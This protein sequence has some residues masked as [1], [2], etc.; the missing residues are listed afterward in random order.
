MRGERSPGSIHAS[1][2]AGSAPRAWGTHVPQQPERPGVRISPT[3]VGNASGTTGFPVSWPDQPHVRGERA[4]AAQAARSG[5]G[6]APRAWGTLLRPPL[7][8]RVRRIS[9]T[10]VGNASLRPLRSSSESDQPHVRGERR[11]PARSAWPGAGSAPRAW[12]TRAWRVRGGDERRISPTCVGNAGALRAPRRS[13]PDQPH[14][15]GERS[16]CNYRQLPD[17]SAVAN[18]TK[19][20]KS[21]ARCVTSQ[22]PALRQHCQEAESEPVEGPRTL[23]ARADWPR[24]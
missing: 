2:Y 14:V 12:G 9:P 22:H 18:S 3:C 21:D 11:T 1:T 6:S 4:I 19:L 13:S 8:P 15:R 10:C 23:R 7:P 20:S 17:F 24:R 5:D 16:S